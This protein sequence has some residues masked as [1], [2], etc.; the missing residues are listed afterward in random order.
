MCLCVCTFIYIYTYTFYGSLMLS[1]SLSRARTSPLLSVMT[2]YTFYIW[3]VYCVVHKTV[4]IYAYRTIYLALFPLWV[5]RVNPAVCVL[6]ACHNVSLNSRDVFSNIL[7]IYRLRYLLGRV[8]F[9]PALK[10]KNIIYLMC[11]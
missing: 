9:L 2:L 3:C 1:C 6:L 8:A 11:N 10:I 4:R 7:Y 5:L